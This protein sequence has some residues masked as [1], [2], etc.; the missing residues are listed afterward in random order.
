MRIKE[1]VSMHT[2]SPMRSAVLMRPGPLVMR[3]ALQHV[4]N[5]GIGR[6]LGCLSKVATDTRS[7]VIPGDSKSMSPVHSSKESLSGRDKEQRFS[8]H[9]LRISLQN[10]TCYK[11][12]ESV[13]DPE[14]G[15]Y[16]IKSIGNTCCT[17]D[18]SKQHE[19]THVTDYTAA[20]CCKAFGKA[21]N[22]A[23]KEEDVDALIKK[24]NDWFDQ[25][26]P[27]S[28]CHAYNKGTE[29]AKALAKSKD[30]GG[31]GKDTDC[32]KDITAFVS[33]SGDKAKQVCDAAPAKMPAC[34]KF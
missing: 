30:C 17:K 29:C 9:G 21:W 14:S 12:S 26:N 34:P 32:C 8:K 22:A 5:R 18:C 4:G 11:E 20:G 1:S 3:T 2:P 15:H 7:A 6:M 23:T 27:V 25:A 13:C 19:Q 33:L 28:E 16:K 24:Y 10:G 31:K